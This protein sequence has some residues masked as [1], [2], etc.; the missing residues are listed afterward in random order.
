MTASD[1]A[2]FPVEV[3]LQT[4]TGY[5]HKGKLDYVSPTLNQST[6]TL[7]VRGILPT[8]ERV[9]LPGYYV[10]VRVSGRS[11]ASGVAGSRCHPRQRSGRTICAGRERLSNVVEQRKVQTGPLDRGDLRVID[12]G[13]KPD[14]RV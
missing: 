5:P 10:R 8:T 4:E 2:Q 9:L 3:G 13:L 1:L 14:D 11:A 6:G 7:P 12:S